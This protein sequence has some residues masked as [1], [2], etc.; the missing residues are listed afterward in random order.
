VEVVL[1]RYPGMKL[2]VET[3][4]QAELEREKFFRASGDCLCPRCS[5]E[6]WK[7]P[8][9]AVEEWLHVLCNGERVKL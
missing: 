8:E 6:Y 5:Y 1:A 2:P 4:E 9:D 7:H 3:P